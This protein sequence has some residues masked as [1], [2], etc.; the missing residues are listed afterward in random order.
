MDMNYPEDA[1]YGKRMISAE[2]GV[3]GTPEHQ[4]EWLAGAARVLADFPNIRVVSYYDSANAPNN[5]MPT[6]PDWRISRTTFEEVDMQS[7]RYRRRCQID[8][9]TSGGVG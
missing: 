5:H 4:R 2:L 1:V 6:Q 9:R 8:P 3:S 7:R